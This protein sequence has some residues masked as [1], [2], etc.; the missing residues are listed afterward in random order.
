MNWLKT[1]GY[2]IALWAII[3]VVA[4]VC[5]ALKITDIAVMG[6]IMVIASIIVLWLLSKQYKIASLAQGIQVG[7]VWLVITAI[8]EYVI[9]VR[10]FLNG[11]LSL[12]TSWSVITGYILIVVVPAVYGQVKK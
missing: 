12:Y 7:L 11:D 1:I 4:S 5:I 2:G 9:T 6:S 8:L 3:F 10:G